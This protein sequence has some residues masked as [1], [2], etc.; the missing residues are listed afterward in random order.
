MDG[1]VAPLPRI[2]ALAEKHRATL[3]VDDSHATGF[4]GKT[5]RGTWEHHGVGGRWT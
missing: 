3:M 1:T 2:C 4:M 5:G